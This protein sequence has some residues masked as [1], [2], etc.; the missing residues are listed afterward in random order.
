MKVSPFDHR[1][2][3]ELGKA[4]RSVLTGADEEAFVQRVMTRVAEMHAGGYAGLAWWE[5]LDTWARPGLVAAALGLIAGVMIWA[6]G[7]TFGGENSAALGDPLQAVGDSGVPA[8]FL[9]T[10]RPPSLNEV[11]GAGLAGDGR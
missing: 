4:L 2:D 1:P 10:A 7:L 11:M 6:G 8:A 3:R 5:V 9:A